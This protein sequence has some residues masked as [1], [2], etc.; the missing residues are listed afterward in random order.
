MAV[1]GPTCGIVIYLVK[2]NHRLPTPSGVAL[3]QGCLCLGVYLRLS[4]LL[5]QRVMM[6]STNAADTTCCIMQTAPRAMVA[7]QRHHQPHGPAGTCC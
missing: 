5:A 3:P 6:M 7:Y 1:T 2:A 4:H